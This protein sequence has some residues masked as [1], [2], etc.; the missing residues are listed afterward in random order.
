[1]A[2]LRRSWPLFFAIAAL[3][4]QRWAGDASVP[5]THRAER[6]AMVEKL[7]RSGISNTYVLKAMGQV[8]RDA[9]VSPADQARA[10]DDVTIPVSAGQ[11]LPQPR[12]IALAMEKLNPDPK[13]TILQVGTECAYC[14]ALLCSITKQVYVVDQ[15][16]DVMRDAKRNLEVLGYSW[17]R[18]HEG[19]GC[20]GWPEKVTFDA[21]LVMCAA[22]E[23]P[24]ALVKQLKI[25]GRMVIPIGEG[26]EQTLTCVTKLADGR[27][28]T[29]AVAT[30]LPRADMMVCR[31]PLP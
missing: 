18:W 28:R 20:K 9:F 6:A 7:R 25:E 16:R 24:E 10:Y 4:G 26:P 31:K 22:D 14:T 30:S 19:R 2:R 1:V 12:A 27:L 5:A 8:P 13:D 21:I 17:A 3:I 11:S 15:R 29:E 23:V